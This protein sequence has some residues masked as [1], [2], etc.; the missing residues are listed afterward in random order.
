MPTGSCEMTGG[1]GIETPRVW[2]RNYWCGGDPHI[3]FEGELWEEMVVKLQNIG[4][5]TL[6]SANEEWDLSRVKSM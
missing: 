1:I 4:G 2:I 6:Q 5:E 3:P